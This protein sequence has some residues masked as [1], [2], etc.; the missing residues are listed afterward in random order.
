[1][2]LLRAVD[3]S[4][5]RGASVPLLGKERKRERSSDLDERSGE[6]VKKKSPCFRSHLDGLSE[7]TGDELLA[8]SIWNKVWQRMVRQSRDCYQITTL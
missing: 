1:M 7:R 6:Q 5:G 4:D 2:S 8:W 3:V